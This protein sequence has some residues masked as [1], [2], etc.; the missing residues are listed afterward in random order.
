MGKIPFKMLWVTYNP[1][2]P[3]CAAK[4]LVGQILQLPAQLP[5]PSSL[6]SRHSL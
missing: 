2:L 3:L 6:G 5:S 1:A 4:R